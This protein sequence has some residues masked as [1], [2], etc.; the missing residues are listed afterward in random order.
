ME[1]H[2]KANTLSYNNLLRCCGGNAKTGNREDVHTCDTKKAN[3]LI[4]FSP[5]NPLHK[6]NERFIYFNSGKVSSRDSE[7][8]THINENL[9]LNLNL[10]VDNRKAALDSIKKQ[11]DSL[12]IDRRSKANIKLLLDK[13]SVKD[14]KNSYIPFYGA[15]IDYLTKKLR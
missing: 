5:S 2:I 1:D 4:K 10:M 13:V 6:I 3:K 15:A 14:K 7:F 11:L 8:D 12:S 9:N